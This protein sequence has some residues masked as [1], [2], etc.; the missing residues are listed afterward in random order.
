MTNKNGSEVAEDIIR[1]LYA[2]YTF[3]PREIVEP[4]LKTLEEQ[5]GEKHLRMLKT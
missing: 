2:V 4:V 1:L 3:I 5:K